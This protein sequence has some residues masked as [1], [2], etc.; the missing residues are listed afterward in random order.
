M[1]RRCMSRKLWGEKGKVNPTSRPEM[2]DF[3]SDSTHN[4][5]TFVIKLP[6]LHAKFAVNSL[7]LSSVIKTASTCVDR[8]TFLE[9]KA[10][11]TPADVIGG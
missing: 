4:A 7:P 3:A 10:H 9:L 1:N 2:L 8:V 11:V 6:S 5:T